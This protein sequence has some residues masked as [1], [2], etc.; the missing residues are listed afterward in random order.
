MA[1]L[2]L[3]LSGTGVANAQEATLERA[4]EQLDAGDYARA[5]DSLSEWW[6]GLEGE[7]VSGAT[8][9]RA[10][11]LRARLAKD[12]AEAENDYLTLV[13]SHPTTPQVPEALLR[14]G[15]GLLATDDLGRAV[16]YLERLVTDHPGSAQ[17]PIGMLWLARA[18]SAAGRFEGACRVARDGVRLTS[19]EPSLLRLI[20]A[21]EEKACTAARDQAPEETEAAPTP[22][23]P[24]SPET[25]TAEE[26][27]GRYAVQTGAFRQPAGAEQLIRRLREAGHD[28]RAVRIP[29][30][31]L[32]RVRVGRFADRE[33]TRGL[34]RELQ[35][36]GF[37]AMVV[38][39]VDREQPTS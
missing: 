10:L 9:A 4:E 2:A 38:A 35:G 14:L 29:G 26:S 3:V 1:L 16:A 15:Q 20:Q 5:R 31:A 27:D 36:A 24:D 37:E 33:A 21:E 7:D 19:S 12:P 6:R 13:L 23:S 30:S 34:V 39:D 28:A 11:F 8:R 18:R 32:V 25:E 22:E 17:R